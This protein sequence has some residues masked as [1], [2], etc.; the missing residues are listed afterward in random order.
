MLAGAA[1]GAGDSERGGSTECR[2]CGGAKQGSPVGAGTTRPRASF[3]TPAMAWIR[4]IC[5]FARARSSGGTRLV[6]AGVQRWRGTELSPLC[7]RTQRPGGAG[8]ARTAALPRGA[9][10]PACARPKRDARSL[11]GTSAPGRG[12][13]RAGASVLRDIATSPH[14]GA[15]PSRRA[16][17]AARR[18]A[19]TIC[20]ALCWFFSPCSQVLAPPCC[21]LF[22]LRGPS[23]GPCTTRHAPRRMRRAGCGAP[24]P[25]TRPR[26]RRRAGWRPADAGAAGAGR[27]AGAR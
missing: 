21:K 3:V 19:R 26:D 17:C 7:A 11:R 22:F 14:A 18:G 23:R 4:T 15:R 2:Q 8:S 13:L 24:L 10:A 25:P 27:R 5:I 9:V 1:A 16:A 20:A 6:G 12:S